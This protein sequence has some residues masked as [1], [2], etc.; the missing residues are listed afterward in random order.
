LATNVYRYKALDTWKAGQEGT[1]VH[2]EYIIVSCDIM[3]IMF[4]ISVAYCIFYII[5]QCA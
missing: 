1:A 3:C 4:A 5:A 2:S